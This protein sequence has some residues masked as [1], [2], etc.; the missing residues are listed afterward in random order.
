MLINCKVGNHSQIALLRHQLLPASSMFTK[1]VRKVGRTYRSV[2]GKKAGS[3]TNGLQAFESTLERDLIT[4]LDFD[5]DVLCYQVQP[6]TIYYESSRYTPDVAVYFHEGLDRKPVLY[7]VKY[8]AELL[9]K[10]EELQPKFDA[11]KE[12]A[13]NNGY[14]FKVITE[15]EIRTDRLYNSKFLCRYTK[16]APNL[17]LAGELIVL[18]RESHQATVKELLDQTAESRRPKLLHTIWQLLAQKRIDADLTKE[19]TLLSPIWISSR[20]L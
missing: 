2:S 12:Y 13:A 19:L 8:T 6:V 11:A 16:P 4:L 5:D 14:E 1:P 9:E 7:E 18:L 17:L 15:I 3:K 20:T 10:Q